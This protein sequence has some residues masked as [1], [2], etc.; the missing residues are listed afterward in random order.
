MHDVY[1]CYDEEDKIKADSICHLF[2]QHKIKCWIK[3]RDYYSGDSVDKISHAIRNSKCMV[4][5]YSK[6]S[7]VSNPVVTEVDIAFSSGIPILAFN[8]DGTNKKG[9]LE[10][11][12]KN[13]KFINA[14]PNTRDQLAL[15]VKD[16][17][18]IIDNPCEDVEIPS[19]IYKLFERKS[20][21]LKYAKIAIPIIVILALVVYFVIIPMGQHTTD[22]GI[23]SM[24][25]TTV[26]VKDADG[27]YFYTV[28]GE[29]NNLPQN[30][31]L[32][33]MKTQYFD[34]ENNMVYEINTSADEFRFGVIASFDVPQKNITHVSFKLVDINDNLICED[35]Y[36]L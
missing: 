25:I 34:S 12:L 10:F 17:S 36:R 2:E 32:Y 1:I 7:K 31:T 28:H 15:L 6:N 35:E 8:I 30:S 20:K 13:K 14:F 24:N 19:N 21:L 18:E 16:T 5:L 27:K 23:F 11:F 29:S 22:D 4:I 9:D 26:D 33:F 3:S